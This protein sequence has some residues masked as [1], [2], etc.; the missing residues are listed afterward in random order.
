MNSV[1]ARMH[2][3]STT[4]RSSR[5]LPR[6]YA[7][8]SARSAAGVVPTTRLPKRAG[9]LAGRTPRSDTECPRG[10][11][12][13]A[14]RGAPPRSGG[15]ASRCE[16]GRRRL[17]R[18]RSRLVAASTCTSTGVVSSEP[19]R[20]TSPSSS[21]R[22]SLACTAS[23]NSPISSRKIVP[24]SASFEQPGLVVGGAGEG[25]PHVPEQLAFEQRFDDRR[26][27]DGDEPLARARAG[28]VERARHELL[29]RC[30]F[31]R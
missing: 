13:A 8:T 15:T 31:R 25:A 2:A 9:R 17:R 19:T 12:A 18:W 28:L 6:Q 27:V 21:T 23:G 22:S 4:L 7:A 1:S 11:R 10:A 3:R 30:R 26:A 16:S 20:C 14:A 24:P 5:T 29:A